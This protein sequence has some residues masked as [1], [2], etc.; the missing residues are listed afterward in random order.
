[1]GEVL[2]ETLE[3]VESQRQHYQKQLMELEDLLNEARSKAAESE[4]NSN[5]K[6]VLVNQLETEKQVNC[7]CFLYAICFV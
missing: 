2:A 4:M 3:T 7:Q 1:M 6:A 5:E